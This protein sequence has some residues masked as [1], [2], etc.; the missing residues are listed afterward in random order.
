MININNYIVSKDITIRDAL[1]I[2]EK[3]IEKCLFAINKNK[4]LIGTL[5]D[6]DVRR[7]M[8]KRANF[9]SKIEKYL[10][11]KPTTITKGDYEKK[12]FNLVDL[13]KQD[14]KLIPVVSKEK[15]ILKIINPENPSLNKIK[16]NLIFNSIPVLIMAGGRGLR[17]KPYT[18]IVPK[19]LVPIN[20]ISMIEHVL[21]NFR[22]FGFKNFFVSLNYKSN[23]IRTFFSLLKKKYKISFLKETKPLG[24][25]GVIKNLKLKKKKDFFVINCDTI[26]K[27]DFLSLYNF[28]IKKKNKLTL[29]A[30]Q[31]LNSIPYGVCK[32]NKSHNLRKIIEKPSNN[33]LVNT[34]CYV[35]N[36][37]ILRHIKKNQKLDMNELIQK[38]L[39]KKIKI[40]VFPVQK[41]AWSDFGK[42]SDFTS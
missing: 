31:Q 20:G 25:A 24:T 2:L 42:I 1:K 40:G 13:K 22:N 35:I 5:T 17:L 4:K 14:F 19:P 12:N 41:E 26:L 39:R 38:L 3:N 37:S 30:S 36:S 7:A 27:C 8:L 23:L 11:K 29:V 16:S 32:L 6:G 15:K 18:D 28:H 34:G 33:I 21:I 9:S 10:N